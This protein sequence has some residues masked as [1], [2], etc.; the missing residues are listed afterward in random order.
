MSTTRPLLAAAGDDEVAGA[1]DSDGAQTQR[2][3][4]P[5]SSGN[6]PSGERW[7][8]GREAG[9]AHRNVGQRRRRF[10]LILPM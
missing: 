7:R 2:R 9:G 10:L 1:S 3:R 8:D 5:G 4:L 6:K